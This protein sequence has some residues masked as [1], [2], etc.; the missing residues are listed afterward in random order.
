MN[1]VKLKPRECRVC[2]KKL[3]KNEEFVLS[4]EYPSEFKI[5]LWSSYAPPEVYGEIYHKSCFLESIKKGE[6]GSQ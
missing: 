1:K 5:L 3:V 6:K 4:G 2:G